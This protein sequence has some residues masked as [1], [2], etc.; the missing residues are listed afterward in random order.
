M[1]KEERGAFGV[2]ASFVVPFPFPNSFRLGVSCGVESD[3]LFLRGGSGLSGA[4]AFFSASNAVKPVPRVAGGVLTGG[5]ESLGV[6]VEGI[7]EKIN[8]EL[9]GAY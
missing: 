6:L 7:V 1:G 8:G 5:L 2:E 4:D 9:F 3:L